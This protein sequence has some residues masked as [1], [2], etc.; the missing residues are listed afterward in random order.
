MII[1]T[2][3][4]P[5]INPEGT[6]NLFEGTLPPLERAQ[7]KIRKGVPHGG[8]GHERSSWHHGA[9]HCGLD[10]RSRDH[11]VARQIL[12]SWLQTAQVPKIGFWSQNLLQAW[13]LE[14]ETCNVESGCQRPHKHKDPHSTSEAHDREDF[15]KHGRWNPSVYMWSM[16]PLLKCCC[17]EAVP[18]HGLFQWSCGIFRKPAT[19]GVLVL[20]Y[21]IGWP[22][23]CF[24]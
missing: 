3:N 7:P 11:S 16:G 2:L 17:M 4:L 19:Q 1:S 23:K 18:E 13:C 12:E 6:P 14:P 10:R 21:D 5:H 9:R 15:R 22:L 8:A 20:R 24:L